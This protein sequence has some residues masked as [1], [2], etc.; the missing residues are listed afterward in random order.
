VISA[1]VLLGTG[2]GIA[3]FMLVAHLRGD[4][5]EIAG[6]AR[7][8][9]SRLPVPRECRAAVAGHRRV[10]RLV[11]HRHSLLDGWIAL[12]IVT[13]AFLA[14]GGGNADAH[15]R[16]KSQPLRRDALL[17]LQSVRHIARPNPLGRLQ[18]KPRAPAPVR[19]RLADA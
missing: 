2:A 10:A 16:P 9:S 8:A 7:T 12:Y 4:P 11:D 13:G 15:A 3:F 17:P 19:G 5:H 1:A 18:R 6:V 14:V